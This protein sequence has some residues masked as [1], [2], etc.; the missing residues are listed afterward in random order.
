MRTIQIIAA[1][2]LAGS[3]IAGASPARA[4]GFGIG[5]GVGVWAGPVGHPGYYASNY[6]PYSRQVIYHQPYGGVY[7]GAPPRLVKRKVTT[8][9]VAAP[10]RQYYVTGYHGHGPSGYGYYTGYHW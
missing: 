9:V 1:A 10:P 5:V 4:Q 3:A 6:Y 2:L 7:Y 8:Y